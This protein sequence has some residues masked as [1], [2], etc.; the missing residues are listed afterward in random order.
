MSLTSNYSNLRSLGL[1]TKRSKI[2]SLAGAAALLAG[3]GFLPACK[4]APMQSLVP[5]TVN[6][7][8]DYFCTW[9]I[10]GYYSSYATGAL[11]KDAV[12]E[13]QLFGQWPN[14]NWLGQYAG[15]RGDLYFLL[16]EG[17]D[18][19]GEDVMVLPGR[20]PGSGGYS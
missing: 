12:Q 14:Q 15:V 11:Q 8:P 3:S 10:Q 7:S 1:P 2:S 6:T 9:N 18:L 4:A 5:T 13:S 17:W 19:P 16:D 20:F